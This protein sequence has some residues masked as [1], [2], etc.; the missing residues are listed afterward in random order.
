MTKNKNIKINSNSKDKKISEQS[1]YIEFL[2]KY[3][4]KMS[5]GLTTKEDLKRMHKGERK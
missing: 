5:F 2:E 1:S 3:I 4:Y